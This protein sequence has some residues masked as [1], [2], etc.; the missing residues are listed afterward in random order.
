VQVIE[1]SNRI[2]GRMMTLVDLPGSPNAG[3]VQIGANY[4]R[5]IALCAALNVARDTADSVRRETLHMIGGQTVRQADW[6][7]SP[8]NPFPEDRRTLTP[9]S[10]LMVLAAAGNPV[11]DTVNWVDAARAGHDISASSFL[12]RAGVSEAARRLVDIGLNAN[13][14]DTYS[15]I[16]VWRSLHLFAQDRAAGALTMVRN[17]SQALPSA[18]AAGLARPVMLRTPVRQITTNPTGVTISLDRGRTMRASHVVCTLPQPALRTVRIDAPLSMIQREAIGQSTYTAILQLHCEALTPWWEADGLPPDMWTD[19]PLERVFAG[20]DNRT[21]ELTGM[22]TMWINGTG[23]SAWTGLD[24]AQTESRI[25]AELARL[26]PASR[27]QIRL[28]RIVNWTPT[29][30]FAGGAYIHYRPGQAAR[31]GTEPGASV[32]HLHFAGEHLSHVATG[33]EGAL[34]SAERAVA[35]VVAV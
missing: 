32:G 33:L 5:F 9:A 18:M 4:R 11:T 17:G 13:A 27:G 8:L 14:L 15:M 7:T 31:W 1:A 23:V 20:R 16:N 2:G 12:E 30:G 26:R 28:R 29:N 25:Q 3:G 24:E 22:M 6:V 21:G 10:A 34:E 19:T 35:A